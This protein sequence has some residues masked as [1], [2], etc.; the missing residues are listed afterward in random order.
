MKAY[1]VSFILTLLF[2]YIA[3]KNFKK[4]KNKLGLIFLFISLVILV[5]I[6]G[7]RTRLIGV[8][9]SNYPLAIYNL[10]IE[11][12]SYLQILKNTKVEPLFTLIIYISAIFK[13]YNVTMGTIEL[14]C[15]LPIY[16]Y[17]FKSRKDKSITFVIFIFLTT[18]YAKSFNLQ[19]QFI[20]ISFL[21]LAFYYYKQKHNKKTTFLL[22][23]ASM[24]HYTA[25]ISILILI[26]IRINLF[27]NN[28]NNKKRWMILLTL[29]IIVISVLMSK[30]INVLPDK[31]A[32]YGNASTETSFTLM[33]LVKKLF[34]ITVS[35]I[36][37]LK[38]NTSIKQNN[39]NITNL[40]LLFID[41][42]FYFISVKI[43]IFGRLG[44]YFIYIV[45]FD[46][47]PN[48][49]KIF[50]QKKTAKI[51]L[52]ILMLF[53]WYNMTVTNFDAD[54]TY[55]YQSTIAPI[56]NDNISK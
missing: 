46:M 14:I 6:A 34:W 54:K 30:I 21:V 20:A 1:V 33:G 52:M 56:L 28:K 37:L 5:V 11:G 55:P 4:S 7:L 23:I 51:F 31:Y 53:L 44:Y 45:Y 50:K 39:E 22:I 16:I 13:N 27:Y 35:F 25:I 36:M 12:K 15:A 18:M 9:S 43:S 41:L 2:A 3:E 48:I 8:D 32:Q 49:P 47:I 42:I 17:A 10:S 19:R 26:I 40:T 24:F 38:F 29:I